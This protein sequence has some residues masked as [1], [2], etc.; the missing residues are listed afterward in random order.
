MPEKF[1][2]RGNVGGHRS[3]SSIMEENKI[4]PPFKETR[5]PYVQIDWVG[6]WTAA[7]GS[8]IYDGGAWPGKWAPDDRYS[9][10]LSEA[11]MHIFHHEFLDPK[12]STYQGRKEEDRKETHFMTSTDYWFRP[13]HSRVGPDGAMYV[14]DFTIRSLATMTRAAPRSATARATPPSARIATIISPAS[15]ACSTTRP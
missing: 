2:A 14:V 5:K 12:G 9:F 15:I 13:I 1:L 6:A 4:Y 10:F 8:A 11:T 7:T 3:F